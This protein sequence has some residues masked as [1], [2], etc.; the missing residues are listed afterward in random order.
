MTVSVPADLE[1]ALAD[2]AR[3]RQ[4]PAEE[5]VR[6]ALRWYLQITPELWDELDAWQEVRDEALDLAEG[7]SA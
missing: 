5:L 2:I 6:D 1:K 7:G 3:E 4:R